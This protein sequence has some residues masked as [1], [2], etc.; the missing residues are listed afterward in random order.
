MKRAPGKDWVSEGTWK[1]IAKRASLLR[2]GKIR[3]TDAR[4]MKREVHAALKV[5]KRRLTAQVGENIVSELG[6]GNVQEAFWHLKGWYQ[7]ASKAQARPCHQTMER[8]TDKQVELYAERDAYGAEFPANGTPFEIDDYP[9]SEEELRTAVSQ[10]SHG[11]C[12]GASGI[13][14]KHIKEWLRRA[15]KEEDP[16]NEATHIGAGKLWREFVEICTSVLATGN[17]PQ[18]LCWVVMVLIPKGGGEYR[19]ISLLEPIWKVMER[20]MDLRLEKIKLHDSLHGCLV[21]RGTG[22]GIIEAKLAQQLAHLKQRPFFGVFIDLKKAFDAMDRGRC[23]TILALHGVG[24]QML[25]LIRNFWETAMDVCRAKGNYGRPFK[26]GRAVTQGGALSAKLFNILVNAVI[27]EWMRIM[28]ETLGDSDGQLAIRVKELFAIFYVD[29]GYI[30]S[31]DAEFLQEALNILGVTFKRTGLAT[32]TK[33]MQA[34]V[35]TPG[36]V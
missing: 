36:F 23:L 3:Q 29:D 26:A 8:Q 27:R 7:T 20:V 25:R 28:R 17:I 35:C 34:M 33:K 19:G 10:L 4:R 16:E 6:K 13:R 9:P 14:A 5:D 15:K 22:T 11:R 21:G 18:Q 31:R 30:A 12:G 32:N 24:P 1:L 2:S